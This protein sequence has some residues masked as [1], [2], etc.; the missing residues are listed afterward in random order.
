LEDIKLG[1]PCGRI[2]SPGDG[3]IDF[4]TIF[5]KLAQYDFK[6]WAVME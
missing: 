1:K 2:D 5:N 3:Q 6:G 4:K